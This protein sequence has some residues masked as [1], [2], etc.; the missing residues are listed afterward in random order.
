[1]TFVC[2][3]SRIED[4]SAASAAKAGRVGTKDDKEKGSAGPLLL[5]KKNGGT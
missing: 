1:V 5:N 4:K 3:V 2:I